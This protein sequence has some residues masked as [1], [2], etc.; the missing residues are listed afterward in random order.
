ML[1]QKN[2]FKKLV[3]GATLLCLFAIPA[4]LALDEPPGQCLADDIPPP[5]QQ[6]ECGNRFGK[7]VCDFTLQNQNGSYV[8]LSDF[9]GKVVLLDATA[10]WCGPCKS[11]AAEAR[12][13]Q[14][15]YGTSKFV[16]LTVLLDGMTRQ[17]PPTSE[18]VKIWA[19]NYNLTPNSP[20]LLG[21]RNF[22][23]FDT[24]LEDKFYLTGFPTFYLIGPKGRLLHTFV[25][26]NQVVIEDLVEQ[27]LCL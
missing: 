15:K 7:T 6:D 21:D 14:D 10:A 24:A 18:L 22:I 20:V 27:A 11:A 9:K 25:G 19:D 8:S 1:V 3:F 12:A 2:I 23:T 4:C 17:V 26:F 13:T 5:T 16:Y